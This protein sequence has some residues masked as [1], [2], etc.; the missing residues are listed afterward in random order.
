MQKLTLQGVRIRAKLAL[1]NLG[2]DCL[3][4]LSTPAY[5]SRKEI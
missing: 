1:F 3:C 4:V 2:G 5:L